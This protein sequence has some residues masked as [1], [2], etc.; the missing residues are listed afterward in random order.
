[1]RFCITIYGGI[2][3]IQLQIIKRAS[4]FPTPPRLFAV[5]L[6]LPNSPDHK[7]RIPIKPLCNSE[8]D[9]SII[10]QDNNPPDTD[11][12][13]HIKQPPIT[14]PISPPSN[15]E[16][17]SFAIPALGIFLCSPL[18]S[19]IDN[20]FVGRT[21][22][23]SGLAALSPA[24]ICTDQMIYLFSFLS[25]ATTGIVS[26]AY[27]ANRDGD[28]GNIDAA[29]EASSA[30]LF[31][32]LTCGFFLSI[33]YALYTPKMLT[34]LN[35]N[36]TLLPASKAYVYWRGAIV[37]AALA[38]NVALS[39]LLATRD[40][41]SP[42]KVIGISV[43]INILGDYLLCVWPLRMGCAGAA[44]AT[45]FSTVVSCAFLLFRTLRR[46]KLL[47]NL[48]R[49]PTFQETKELL[50]YVGPL[51]MIVF[52]RLIGFISMQRAAMRLGVTE[53]ATYQLCSN[54]MVFFLLFGEPLSQ[55]HQT[56]LPSL[57]DAEDR[58]GV[59]MT[60]RSV[61]T[62]A[63]A[64]ALGIGGIAFGVLTFG[65]GMFT[66]DGAVKVLTRSTA[67]SVF[68]AVVAAIMGV[69]LDGAM[70]ASK[71][72]GFILTMGITTCV[73]QVGWMKYY[74]SSVPLIFLA[75]AARLG[76]YALAVILRTVMGRGMVGKIL[77][78]KVE[79]EY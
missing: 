19:N 37:W 16:L 59:A 21:V 78:R 70:L 30:P 20:A 5:S 4:G 3:L 63:S 29:R 32:A 40:A 8:K 52:T 44:A 33:F 72:F 41:I 74:A 35:V 61:M 6:N 43:V 31:V 54:A 36:P 46:K 7:I 79:D 10:I 11:T 26:R 28:G 39:I 67:P 25:R 47:P 15:R 66:T 75:F 50:T 64:T 48:L 18:L 13:S 23:T 73:L 60:L 55:L 51:I 57:L 34:L 42:L 27:A 14:T 24:T 12:T 65:S 71:D 22:G 69:V 17:L 45:A 62:L 77:K 53:L 38:Q 56:K 76:I 68:L 1:M 58:E 2:L 9:D 49:I